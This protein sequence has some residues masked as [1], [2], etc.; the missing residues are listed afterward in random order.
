MGMLA[1]WSILNKVNDSSD[2]RFSDT[3]LIV[4]PNL[5]SATASANST[6]RTAR[7]VYYRTRDLV[8]E[9]MPRISSCA[10]SW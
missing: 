3:V 6:R 2:G 8:P 5:T 9:H 4:C 1:A 10:N 7:R